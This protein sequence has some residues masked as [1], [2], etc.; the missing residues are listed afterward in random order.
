MILEHSCR[1]GT[2]LAPHLKTTIVLIVDADN[3]VIINEQC[4]LVGAHRG[5]VCES[6]AI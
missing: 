6:D 3:A 4:N 1:N 5:V 2:A